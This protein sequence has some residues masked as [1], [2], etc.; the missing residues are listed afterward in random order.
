[1]MPGRWAYALSVFCLLQLRAEA[2]L[3]G[4]DVGGAPE[5][6]Y[7]GRERARDRASGEVSCADVIISAFPLLLAEARVFCVAVNLSFCRALKLWC[8][9]VAIILCCFHPYMHGCNYCV[10]L[11]VLSGY[12]YIDVPVFVLSIP[13]RNRHVPDRSIP[14]P[15]SRNI[16]FVFP[17]GFSVPATVPGHIMQERE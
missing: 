14:F 3:P 2:T 8:G 17:S 7:Q 10:E 5:V 12:M 4:E 13:D 16:E 11:I 9:Y 6:R 15:I 1:M